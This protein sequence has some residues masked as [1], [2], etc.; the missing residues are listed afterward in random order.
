[1]FGVGIRYN[2]QYND[3]ELLAYNGTTDLETPDAV[4]LNWNR[5]G[6]AISLLPNNSTATTTISGG[7][8]VSGTATVG[9]ATVNGDMTVTGDLQ[10]DG[11][12]VAANTITAY[13][14][15]GDVKQDIKNESI[16]GFTGSTSEFQT[17]SAS[18]FPQVTITGA[19]VNDRIVLSGQFVEDHGHYNSIGNLYKLVAR[20][21]SATGALIYN[22]PFN[23]SLAASGGDNST[24]YANLTWPTTTYQITA[25]DI[26]VSTTIWVG[27]E[28]KR[29]NT[30][31]VIL[32]AETDQG[33]SVHV[34]HLRQVV[35]PI[36]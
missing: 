24:E 22:I 15:I 28:I 8:A 14:P 1:M 29:R 25:E 18:G 34:T 32:V 31:S 35:V 36:A 23:H 5:E 3:G 33:S 17:L 27:W 11:S 6:T 21:G 16:W 20:R 4:V 13:L 26:A 2:A 7:L 12:I 9:G 30:D 19:Q 10:I